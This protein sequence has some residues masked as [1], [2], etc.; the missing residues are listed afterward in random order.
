[1][2]FLSHTCDVPMMKTTQ[3]R[4]VQTQRFQNSY[5]ISVCVK[6]LEL[7][8]TSFRLQVLLVRRL[9]AWNVNQNK[10]AYAIGSPPSAGL[11]NPLAPSLSVRSISSAAANVGI[12]TKT[13]KEE[14]RNDHASSGTCPMDMSGCLHFRIVTIKFIAPKRARMA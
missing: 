6:T 3:L 2:T 7:F 13:I 1:M 11:K 10:C 14:E 5:C 8:R 12:A 9:E 4:A